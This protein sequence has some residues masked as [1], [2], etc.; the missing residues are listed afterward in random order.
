M[1]Y[2]VSWA[3]ITFLKEALEEFR[4]LATLK[5]IIKVTGGADIPGYSDLKREALREFKFE[6][7]REA[8]LKGAAALSRDER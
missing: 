7:V 8:S 3:M 1:L 5:E 6:S 4:A 2:A